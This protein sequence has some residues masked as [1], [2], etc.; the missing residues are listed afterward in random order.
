MA[1]YKPVTGG[2]PDALDA[3][4]AMRLDQERHA[5]RAVAAGA[6][7]RREAEAEETRLDRAV[8]DARAALAAARRDGGGNELA[9][10]AQA[11]RR[12]WSRLERQIAVAT[13]ALA[14][15]RAGALARAIAAD[16]AARAAHRRA[17]Q[18]REVVDKAIARRRAARERERERRAEAAADDLPRRRST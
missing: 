2:A 8:T 6:A 12:F 17:H 4:A 7:A 1:S 10:E 16:E 3:L 15:H 18:R 9:G 14:S 5:E 13:D 11:R